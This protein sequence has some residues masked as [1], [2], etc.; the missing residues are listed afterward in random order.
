MLLIIM[1]CFFCF[2]RI[3]INKIMLGYMLFGFCFFCWRRIC[4][5]FLYLSW[6]FF[7]RFLV[8]YWICVCFCFWLVFLK[9]IMCGRLW[10]FM[11]LIMI[12]VCIKFLVICEWYLGFLDCFFVLLVNGFCF[13]CYW[14]VLN[15]I[16]VIVLLC[17]IW[18][19]VV[20]EV[21]IVVMNCCLSRL[22]LIM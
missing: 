4:W 10:R 22:Y 15:W 14:E 17:S 16:V 8:D 19:Y 7:L 3:L 11:F 2:W 6:F 18:C 13:L 12:L 1:I 21:V 20:I 5:R 9:W